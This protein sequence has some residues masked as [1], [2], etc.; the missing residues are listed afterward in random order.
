MADLINQ[1]FQA[2]VDTLFAQHGA[3]GEKWQ[4]ANIKSTDIM[5]LARVP[6]LSRQDIV[7]G[8]GRGIVNATT[9]RTGPSWR[10][11]VALGPQVKAYGVYPGGQSGNPGSHYYDNLLETWRKGELHQLVYLKK[12]DEQNTR[13]ISKW[14]LTK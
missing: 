5:H 7:T 12:A 8:G 14:N 1:S 3:I 10:M 6:A 2:A 4:W 11:V 9:E 13:I